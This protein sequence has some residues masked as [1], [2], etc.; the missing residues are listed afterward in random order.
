MSSVKC[1]ILVKNAD[2]DTPFGYISPLW[3]SYGQYGIFQPDQAG[4]LEVSF[5]YSVDSPDSEDL[6]SRLDFTTTNGPNPSYPFLGASQFFEFWALCLIFDP[7]DSG[8]N[9]FDLEYQFSDDERASRNYASLDRAY[10]TCSILA[11][12][13]SPPEPL[14]SLYRIRNPAIL[15]LMQRLASS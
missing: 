9:Q 11:V 15:R 12:P 13:I 3:T 7:F 10:S 1:N 8:S 6:P 14:I 2:D 5:S 4:S